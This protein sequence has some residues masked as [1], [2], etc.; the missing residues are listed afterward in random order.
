VT[1]CNGEHR[2][3][4]KDVDRADLAVDAARRQRDRAPAAQP[5]SSS[6]V[7]SAPS[8]A[9]LLGLGYVYVPAH[10]GDIADSSQRGI[11]NVSCPVPALSLTC[12]PVFGQ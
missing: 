6:A 11:L 4:S 2:W 9:A 1:P 10:P 7:A 3:H 12:Y 5:T 8:T